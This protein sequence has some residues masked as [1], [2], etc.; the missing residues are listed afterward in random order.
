SS[1]DVGRWWIAGDKLCKRWQVWFENK[2]KCVWVGIA[3]DN[4]ITWRHADGS[5]GTG[6]ITAR[7]SAPAALPAKSAP[8]PAAPKP[9][10]LAVVAKPDRADRAPG[11]ADELRALAASTVAIP[12]RLPPRPSHMQAATAE[13]DGIPEPR[14][15]MEP[16][17]APA[18]PRAA[19]PTE[20]L[21]LPEPPRPALVQPT[22][23]LAFAA[24]PLYRELTLELPAVAIRPSTVPSVVQRVA[25]RPQ[26]PVL[27]APH[28][29]RAASNPVITSFKVVNVEEFDVLNVRSGPA[30]TFAV[31]ATIGP[32]GR[33]VAITGRCVGDWCPIR[34]Q[35]RIGWVNS[36]YL[37]P[38][39]GSASP[40]PGRPDASRYSLGATTL[41]R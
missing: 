15:R 39:Q 18:A 34:H 11:A 19:A 10:Q 37:F 35:S 16:T 21:A 32:A 41:S 8:A 12:A 9:A 29:S 26:P 30:E 24:K 40:R 3:P 31:V 20:E 38:E 25:A 33:G 36:F 28:P 14:A 4:R 13:H 2:T 22:N 27:P 1:R 17:A 5:T 6:L 23:R 7:A